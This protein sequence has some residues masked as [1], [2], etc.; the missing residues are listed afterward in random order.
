MSKFRNELL[1][2]YEQKLKNKILESN[3]YLYIV[4][5]LIKVLTYSEENNNNYEVI[6]NNVV[7]I[8]KQWVLYLQDAKKLLEK[9]NS[10][11][12]EDNL[13]LNQLLLILKAISSAVFEG[14]REEKKINV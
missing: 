12:P 11:S 7:Q 3:K 10:L 13:R 1:A 6:K 4:E 9:N 2:L 5:G 14:L 8:M